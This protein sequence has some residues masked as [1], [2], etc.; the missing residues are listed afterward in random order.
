MSQ[1]RKK[2]FSG[3]LIHEYFHANSLYFLTEH[4]EYFIGKDGKFQSTGHFY[5][6]STT[7]SQS[8]NY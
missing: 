4:S 6:K 1:P 3:Y 8:G 2:Y 5:S 7:A